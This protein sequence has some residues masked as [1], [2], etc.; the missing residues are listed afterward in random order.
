MLPPDYLLHISEGAEAISESLHNAI[1]KRIVE[2][3]MIRLQRGDKYILT[4][5]DKW[6]IETMQEAGQLLEDI[7]KEIAAKTPYQQKEIKEAME[8]AGVQSLAYDNGI[9]RAA[10]IIPPLGDMSEYT[11]ADLMLR[12]SPHYVR[13]MQRAYEATLGEWN[14]FTRTMPTSAYQLYVDQCDKAYSLVQSGAVSYTQAFREAI[15]TI[16]KDG[17]TVVYP[18]GWTDTIETAT[19]RAV[20]TGTAQAAEQISIMR[21]KEV[22]S[23][24]RLTSSHMGARPEHQLWQ[25]EIFWVDWNR[26]NALYPALMDVPNPAPA[27][28]ELRAKYR[29]F[30]ASTDIGTVTGLCG[31]NCRHSSSVY[32]EGV[33]NNPFERY[34]DEENRKLY[35]LTQRQRALERRI[36]KTKREAM[37]LKAAVDNA[38]NEEVRAAEDEAY[39]RK[40]ALLARQ[41]KS[42]SEFCKEHNLR[43]LSDRLAIAQWDRKQAAAARGAARRYLKSKEG[44]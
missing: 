21:A 36:R 3:I 7:Q 18:S 9:Y 41:N 15:D 38:P 25:G 6:Q 11:A 14:N 26:L 43:P 5:V 17:V 39:Q 32:I 27:A 35:E 2:R 31:A 40:A 28:P 42:Y 20:R 24:L 1:I 22:G 23:A 12:T 13:M 30:C 8:D 16:C 34:N 10:D 44:E 4:A 29:E 33:S 19:L 37:G